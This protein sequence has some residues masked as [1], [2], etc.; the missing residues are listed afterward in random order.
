MAIFQAFNAAGIGF[1]MSSTSSTGWAFLQ[2]NPYVTTDLLYDDG[3]T[4]AFDVFGSDLIDYFSVTYWSDGYDIIV[5]DLHYEWD[6]YTVLSIKDLNLETTIDDLEQ[7]SWFVSL[8]AG[9]DAFYGNDFAD[10]IRGGY[11]DDVVYGYG[12]DD[13]IFGDA[14]EDDLF[15]MSG[16]D[17]LYGGTGRDVLDGGIG[18]DY[19]SGGAD[20]DRL[21][22]GSG[23]DYFVFDTRPVRGVWDRITDFRP[24]D[25]TIMLDNAVF[26]KVGRDGWLSG[27]AFNIG[28][29]AQDR[30]DRIIYNKK[31]GDLLYD[32]DGTGSS[33]AIK[34]AQL[35]SG[36]QL[37]KS[38]FF[39]L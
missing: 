38:D 20:S 9:D 32:A 8:N 13:I 19:L 28:T 24:S 37:T 35:K 17:D 23:K 2:P 10:L 15:G 12:G 4:A 30:S 11:G 25:D 3:Q 1:D 33:S 39:I 36:L 22:G 16:D 29:K 31:N 21:T 26:K 27:S 14:G 34:F 7:N 5:D 18:S 6:G